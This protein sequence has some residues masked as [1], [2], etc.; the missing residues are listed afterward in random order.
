MNHKKKLLLS[1]AIIGVMFQASVFG[2]KTIVDKYGQLSVKGNYI[3]SQYGDTVQLRGM[4]MF[5]SQWMGKYYNADVVKWLRD[6]WK[7]TVVRAAM[8]VEMGGYLEKPGQEKANVTTL[9]DAALSLGMYVIIDY[10]SHE[11]HKNPEPAKKF[12]AEMA[13]KYGKYPNV[14]YEIYNEPLKDADW[15][16]DLKPYA[17]TII[18]AIREHDPDNIV[19]VGTRQWSQLVNEA[20]LN[21]VKD[22]NTVYTLHFYAGTH[23]Q[24]LREEAKKAMGNGIALFVSEYGTCDAS[25]NGNFDTTRTREWFNF[26]DK[27]KISHCNWSIADKAETA[28][29]LQPRAS[30]T[31]GWT[32]YDLT[33]SG[34]FVRAEIIAKNTPILSEKRKEAKAPK[35]KEK[36]PKKK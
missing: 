12:F 8:G 2:Q 3:M 5:W 10:H 29:A 30:E 6:D 11:A 35:K 26:M 33:P 14:L 17:D 15:N 21:P 24:W 32:E 4:S 23:R 7:C 16:K 18:K 22:A 1:I 31:G 25:G 13:K 27:Y 36:K 19:I 9:V 28:S 20:A 34:K